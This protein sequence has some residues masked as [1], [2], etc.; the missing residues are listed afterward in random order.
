MGTRVGAGLL[1]KREKGEGLE[2][3]PSGPP[4]TNLWRGTLQGEPKPGS[5]SKGF[6]LIL[7]S[8]MVG[9]LLMVAEEQ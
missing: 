6:G 8:E 2:V 5:E 1:D 7:G 9:D 3:S 4:T